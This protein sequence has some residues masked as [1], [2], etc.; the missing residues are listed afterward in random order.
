[1]RTTFGLI[2]AICCLNAI[3]F[4]EAKTLFGSKDMRFGGYGG[5]QASATSIDG[6]AELL[7]GGRGAFLIDGKIAIGGGGYGLVTKL[8]PAHGV[9]LDTFDR[10]EFGY[11]GLDL[12]F[13]IVP[14]AILHGFVGC[15]FGAGSINLHQKYDLYDDTP[16]EDLYDDSRH[17]NFWLIE[18]RAGAELNVTTFFRLCL[19]GSWRFVGDVELYNYQNSDFSGANAG[20]FLKFGG[21]M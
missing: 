18:P 10:L 5:P 4:G 20:I 6:N 15:T 9:P 13:I 7:F 21:G 3:A 14:D 11:G 1:M 2:L 17:D 8:K 16:M 12:D 19:Y